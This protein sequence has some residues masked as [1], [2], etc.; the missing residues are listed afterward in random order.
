MGALRILHVIDHIY[1]TLGYQETFLAKSHSQKNETIVIASNEYTKGIYDANAALLRNQLSRAGLSIEEAIKILRLPVRFR[2]NLFNSP[3]LM[4][5]EKAINNFRPDLIIAHGIV[6]L[7]S[8]R[9]VL[10]KSRLKNCKLLLDDHMTYN[11]TRGGWVNLLYK[12]FKLALTPIFLKNTDVFIAVTNETK[13]FMHDVYA[14]PYE[15]TI[16]IPLGI[17]LDHFYED[18]S[19]REAMRKKCGFKNDEI[20]FVYA[21]K[22]IAAKGVHLLIDAALRIC[23]THS[24][25]RFMIVGGSDSSYLSLIKRKISNSNAEDRFLF[26]DAVP[27][28]ELYKY[29]NAADA[30]VWPLQ[31]SMTMLEAA[32]CGL[33]VIM[34]DKS[35]AT[36]RVSFGNGILYR[37]SDA[38]DLAN[39]M[40]LLLN[41][42]LRKTMSEKALT[43]AKELRWSN[44]ANRFLEV[45]KAE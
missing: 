29:Y 2:V 39:K 34:S 19:L 32:A 37:Q 44:L 9:V 11:A 4:G 31:C 21:G 42:K 18:L 1:P 26:F 13:R 17:D 20:V 3:F 7:T 35:G 28:R 36:E 33:P 45:S 25:V 14:I 24:N 40:T 27:N 41:D 22:I 12:T 6:N 16:V 38:T 10:L 23:R 8:I 30:G 43:C 15:R 5:L